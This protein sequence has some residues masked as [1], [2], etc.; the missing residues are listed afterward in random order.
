MQFTKFA[1]KKHPFVTHSVP[2][3]LKIELSSESESQLKR[4]TV[5]LAVKECIKKI[6]E[7]EQASQ[8]YVMSRNANNT[9]FNLVALL[10]YF[11][12]R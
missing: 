7:G 11:F 2:Q 1:H 10:E 4:L 5:K 3:D 9:T 8:Y 6:R 12:R